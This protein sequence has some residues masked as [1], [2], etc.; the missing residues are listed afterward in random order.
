MAAANR[1]RVFLDVSIGEEPAGR[2]TIE[3]FADKTPKTAE[4]F[5][6]LCTGEHN[7]LSYAK[8]PFHRVIDEFMIQGGDIASGDGTGTTSIYDG[9]FDDENL[10]WREMDAAGLL[11]SANRGKDTNGSQFFLTLEA[12]PHLN[13]KH[14]IFGRLVGGEDT[15]A[16]IAKVKVDGKDCPVTPV[17]VSRCGELEKKKKP[18]QQKRDSRQENGTSETSVDDRGRRRKSDLSADEMDASPP[19]H[20]RRNRRQS[21]NV[22]D[23]GKRGRVIMRS[24]ILTVSLASAVA[25]AATGYPGQHTSPPETHSQWSLQKFTSLVTFGDSYTD[26]SLL[27]YF[28]DHNGSAP[29]VGYVNPANYHSASGGRPWPQYVK[30]YA[31]GGVNLYNYAVAGAVCS[32]NITPRILDTGTASF[33]FPA[34]EQYEVPAFIADA[35]YTLPDGSPFM[36]NPPDETVYAIWIGTNDLGQAALLTDSQ[37]KGTNIVNYTDC[38][39]NQMKSVYDQGGRYFVLMNIAPL[40]LVPLYGLP[41][42][43]GVGNTTS[44]WPNK[45]DNLTYYSYRM[46]EEVVSVNEIFDYK[47]PFLTKI[48]ETF[49]GAEVAIMDMH[50]LIS[51]MYYNPSEYLNGTAPLNVTGFSHQCDVKGANCVDSDSPDSFLFYDALHPGEQAERVFAREFLDVVNGCGRWATANSLRLEYAMTA[52]ADT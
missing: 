31:P 15:L 27:Q 49:E 7:G 10:D 13:G 6:Q 30:Q 42:A 14:T 48:A 3:L 26:D 37:V 50:G 47:T 44:L 39:F 43:G 52:L 9:E 45:G 35:A 23:E 36:I 2:L 21:D 29:P 12:C 24:A 38:V 19:P 22:V 4:N 17:L 51:D 34:I 46:E 28:A 18:Q 8:A 1:P 32:N 33:L 11:C 16:K 25:G 5:R 40:N 20:A 41:E